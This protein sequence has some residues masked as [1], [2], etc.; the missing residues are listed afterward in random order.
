METYG[1]ISLRRSM[2][3][4]SSA[5]DVEEKEQL[6]D[7]DAS[8]TAKSREAKR[9]RLPTRILVTIGFLTVL[10]LAL[11]TVLVVFVVRKGQAHDHPPSWM[12]PERYTKKLF[13]YQSVFGDEPSTES[14]GQWT[15]LIPKGKG[16]IDVDNDTAIPYMHG[17]DQSLPKQQAM[18]SVFHQ[19]HCLYMTRAGYFS[20]RA[21]N[22][23]EVNAGHLAHCWD[24]L[25]QA[26]MCAGDTTLE[27][28]HA[29]PTMSGARAGAP[30]DIGGSEFVLPTKALIHSMSADINNTKATIWPNPHSFSELP[31][32]YFSLDAR[33]A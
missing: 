20:A 33:S 1:D 30:E 32:R 27:W 7:G 18:I 16:W 14:E 5:S 11:I 3:H 12:P 21:G 13:I 19:L 10:N 23:D 28:L 25:R 22:L 29:P 24:Y 9:R 31:G 6:L 8:Q 2:S 26:I 17:M 15:K 4:S